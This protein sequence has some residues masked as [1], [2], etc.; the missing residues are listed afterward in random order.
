MSE[1]HVTILLDGGIVRQVRLNGEPITATV[2]DYDIEG[3]EPSELEVDE[4]GEE[5]LRWEVI[6]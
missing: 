5:F 6:P 1:Q 3:C 2:Q 4:E